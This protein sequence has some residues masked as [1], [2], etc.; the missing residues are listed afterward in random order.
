LNLNK[1]FFGHRKNEIKSSGSTYESVFNRNIFTLFTGNA[2]AFIIPILLYPVLSRIF[3]PDDY[4]LFGLYIGLFGFL[5]IA[6]AG[7]YD[8][9][10]MMPAKDEDASSLIAGGLT[11]AFLYALIVFTIAFFAKGWIAERF[12]N[13]DLEP[14]LL[15]LPLSLLLISLSKLFNA[16]LI[17]VKRFRATSLNKAS[18]KIAESSTQI[19][20]G[21]VKSS[22]GL[23][24]GDLAGRFFNAIFSVYQGQK[25]GFSVSGISRQSIKSNLRKYADF[26]KYSI[27]PSMLNAL[28]GMLPIFIISAFYSTQESGSYN[29]SRIILSVPFALISAGIS[30]VLM[31]QVAERRNSNL[32]IAPDLS[33]LVLKLSIVSLAGVIVLFWAAPVLFAFVFGSQWH[34]AG[35]FT[36]LLIFSYAVSFVVSPFSVLPMMLGKIKWSSYWQVFYFLFSSILWFLRDFRIYQFLL[37]LVVIDIIAYAIYG[38]LIYKGVRN[39]ERKLV[40]GF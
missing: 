14:W 1:L 26:P 27:V 12:N 33:S 19:L 24:L 25:T 18:Q 22:N 9:A 31:Q 37:A 5:E 40:P 11:F 8:F 39:Y 29:F 21:V 30:Q 6:S 4:A 17:R 15:V 13:P 34:E 16:W 32:S 10:V 28:G 38:W 36:R 23:I 2:V 7:R 20:F 35:E 3:S